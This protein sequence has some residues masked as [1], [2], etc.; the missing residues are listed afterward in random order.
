MSDFDA[1]I[2]SHKQ[3][4]TDQE[5]KEMDEKTKNSQLAEELKEQFIKKREEVVLPLFN[6][7]KQALESNEIPVEI[8][9]GTDGVGNPY[10]AVECSIDP[11][12]MSEQNKSVFQLKANLETLKVEHAPFYDQRKGAPTVVKR[13]LGIDSLDANTI[14]NGLS[15]FLTSALNSRNKA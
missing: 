4:H 3:K 8:K 6:K 1:I 11:N 2:K 9:Q 5:K 15:A 13:L 14:N 10:I 7:F 12:E